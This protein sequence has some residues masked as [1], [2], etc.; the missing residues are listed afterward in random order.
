MIIYTCLTNDYID[1]HCDLP[2]GPLYVVFGI[3]DPPKP[4]VG[5][6]IQDLGCPIRS[7]RV[8]K[9]KS[10]FCQPNVYVDASKLHT[11]NEDFIKLSEEI[12]S[13][14]DFFIMQHPHQHTYLEECAEYICR[15]LC[16]EEE[17]IRITEEASAAGYNFSKYFSP[18]CTVLWR[19]GTEHELNNEWWKW[20]EVGGK[21]DQLAFSIALQQINTKYTY[22]NSRDVINKWSDAN[23][24]DGE[25]WKNKGGKY[26]G[27]EVDPISTVDKLSKITK[28][29]KKFRYRAAI[30]REPDQDPVWMFGDRSDYFYKNYRHLEIIS[31][32]YKGWR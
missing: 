1:L 31:G 4:W 24:I 23:P 19:K 9:I 3:Q 27:K 12:L 11:I 13:K 2:E 30:L 25:W 10:P 26:G 29:N 6:P 14:D 17:V 7:S 5:G 8:P 20:Y 16:S 32:T 28:L 18:L 15:G 21:R 22:D